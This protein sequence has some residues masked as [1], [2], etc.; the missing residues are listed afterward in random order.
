MDG[1]NPSLSPV[2]S[3]AAPA[4]PGM[5]GGAPNE[6]AVVIVVDQAGQVQKAVR[7]SPDGQVQD[8][9]GGACP[10]G[11]PSCAAPAM[12]DPAA[13]MPPPAAAAPSMSSAVPPPAM[14]PSPPSAPSGVTVESDVPPGDLDAKVG[15]PSTPVGKAKKKSEGDKKPEPPKEEKKKA[16][17]GRDGEFNPQFRPGSGSGQGKVAGGLGRAGEFNPQ[18]HGAFEPKLRE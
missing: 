8:L 3:P 18:R 17:L 7:C 5:D 2:A 4:M 13:G 15:D 1:L 12:G 10:P 11:D 9:T 6:T 14:P 16:Y